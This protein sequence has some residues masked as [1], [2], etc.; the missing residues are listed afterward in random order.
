MNFFK[1]AQIFFASLSIHSF[2]QEIPAPSCSEILSC[3]EESLPQHGILKNSEGFLYVDLDD[4]Y[5]HKLIPFIECDGF[6]EPP[7]FGDGL[8]GAHITVIYPQEMEEYGIRQIEECGE[9]ISFC[10]QRCQVVHPSRM[11][12][13]D[14]VYFI[15]VEAPELDEIRAKYGLPKREYAFHITIGVKPKMAHSA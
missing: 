8:V 2:A 7:Y 5:V 4:Q 10:P 14:E 1:Y 13:V 9:T 15:V 6:Q 12:G 3:V 11:K